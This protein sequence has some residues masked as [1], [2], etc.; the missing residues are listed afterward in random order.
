MRKDVWK[1]DQSNAPERPGNT[2]AA[3]LLSLVFTASSDTILPA[4]EDVNVMPGVKTA[5]DE[6]PV[7]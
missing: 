4:R 2:A 5:S 7:P 3:P 6:L 1:P